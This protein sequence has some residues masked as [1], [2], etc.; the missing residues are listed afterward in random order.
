MKDRQAAS[1]G[2]LARVPVLSPVIHWMALPVILFLRSGFGFSF[3][4]S[5]A[6]F[7]SCIL[8]VTLFFVYARTEPGAWGKWWAISSF[9]IAAAILYVTHLSIALVR[10]QKRTG[11]HDHDA[12]TPHLLRLL[13]DENQ[14]LPRLDL[15]VHL[16]FEPALV[17]L[18]A[19]L[20]RVMFDER[21]LS[22][23]LIFVAPVLWL[24]SFINW[25]YGVRSEKKHADIMDDAGDKMSQAGG[26]GK[27]PLPKAAG[28]KERERKPR[29]TSASHATPA[30]LERE[31]RFAE[32]LRLM[33]PYDLAQ[34]ESHYRALIK[35]CHPD[36]NENAS[37]GNAGAA[38][39]NAAIEY[40]RS[41]LS[42]AP[43]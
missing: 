33:P 21:P 14:H 24:K 32:V 34:A 39:L 8:P 4:G 26:A 38:D 18:A 7:L 3:L 11:K 20:L 6:V 31:R 29:A 22:A 36:Q 9:G 30:D 35:T 41:S 5:K 37:T 2:A 25:W 19:L 10:E 15:A 42:A 1:A 40:F 43:E 23:W 17:L 27:A 12:G 13:G 16:W 28:R